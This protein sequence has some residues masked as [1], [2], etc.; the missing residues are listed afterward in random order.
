M[1]FP[2]RSAEPPPCTQQRGDLPIPSTA[3]HR[4]PHSNNSPSHTGIL[5]HTRPVQQLEAV[6]AAHPT[7]PEAV[8]PTK[9]HSSKQTRE[10]CD[11]ELSHRWPLI[12]GLSSP[13]QPRTLYLP[14]Q[15]AV[16][17]GSC[18]SRI[19][20]NVGPTENPKHME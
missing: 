19:L 5:L 9:P 7:T 8:Q 1:V 11:P 20:D 18:Y 4:D 15:K 12:P 16:S 6:Q 10:T 14:C 17:S 13:H 3:T 2:A